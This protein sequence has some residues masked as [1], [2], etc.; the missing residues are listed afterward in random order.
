[1]IYLISFKKI[2]LIPL[3]PEMNSRTLIATPVSNIWGLVGRCLGDS[4][5]LV[6]SRSGRLSRSYNGM[7]CCPYTGFNSHMCLY[8]IPDSAPWA[9]LGSLTVVKCYKVVVHIGIIGYNMVNSLLIMETQLK[10]YQ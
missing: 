9:S 4:F 1:M 6:V 3:L 7:S 5:A 8:V 10:F 2:S